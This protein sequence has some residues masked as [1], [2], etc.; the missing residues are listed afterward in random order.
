M[1]A[2]ACQP[3][4]QTHTLSESNT[5]LEG[6]PFPWLEKLVPAHLLGKWFEHS[7]PHH[8]KGNHFSNL[9]SEELKTSFLKINKLAQ[10]WY[11][12]IL[13]RGARESTEPS[14]LAVP[15]KQR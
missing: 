14:P 10:N 2:I 6:A 8:I 11:I 9:L 7:L 13:P 12:H 4:A 5:L 1:L 15:G 3:Q